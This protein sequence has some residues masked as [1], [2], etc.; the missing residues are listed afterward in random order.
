M[1]NTRSSHVVPVAL[2]V[3]LCLAG[4]AAEHW[5]NPNVPEADWSAD[6]EDCR[7]VAEGTAEHEYDLE[8]DASA[9]P[10]LDY[11]APE[12]AYE[13]QMNTMSAEGLDQQ[14]FRSCMLQKGYYL[15]RDKTK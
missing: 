6:E 14:T 2:I 8:Q 12:E 15:V 13:A 10:S 4:C 3:T 5:E 1:K 9:E 11:F 7:E